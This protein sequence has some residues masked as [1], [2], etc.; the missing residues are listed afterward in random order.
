MTWRRFKLALFAVFV[1]VAAI[2]L[3]IGNLAGGIVTAALAVLVGS[4]ALELSLITRV[5][6]IYRIASS[7]YSK[8]KD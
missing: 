5:K 8:K 3:M 6:K 7:L 2:R 1:I 4:W